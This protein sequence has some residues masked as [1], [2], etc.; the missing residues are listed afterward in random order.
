MFCSAVAWGKSPNVVSEI[1]GRDHELMRVRALL[2]NTTVPWERITELAPDRSG[3]ISALL[4][5]GHVI[6]LT[7]V[8]TDNLPKVLAA[9][10]QQ[11]GHSD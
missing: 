11:I 6:R 4:D 1:V 3:Q 8:T 2:G 9:G 5:N 7:A 10:G